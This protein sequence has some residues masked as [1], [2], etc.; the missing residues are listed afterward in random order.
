ML[1]FIDESGDSGLQLN[2][3]SSQ[4]FT[5][6]MVVFEE[7]DEALACDQR[8]ELL[9]RELGWAP[10]SEFHFKNNSARVREIFLKAVTRYNF[11]YYGLVLN[12]DPKK[13]WGDGFKDKQSF[14]K[15]ACGLVFENAKGKL[16]N[17]TVV[18]DESGNLEFK[19]QLAK[20]LKSKLNEKNQDKIIKNVKMQRSEQNNLLQ[21]ADYVAGA[22]N[23]SIRGTKKL[24]QDYRKIISHREIRVQIW[25]K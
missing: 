13:L 21:L 20:Y 15:Y 6:A 16:L 22:L 8:I 1:V 7:N 25:P 9:K 5:I 17:A 11:F 12:K 10:D 18:V 4:Y 19:R 2:K 3:G 23:R 24:A 14:Y